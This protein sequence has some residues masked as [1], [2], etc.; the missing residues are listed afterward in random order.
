MDAG[1]KIYELARDNNAEILEKN[2]QFY[3]SWHDVRLQHW[4]NDA[5]V[6]DQQIPGSFDID[7]YKGQT[8]VTLFQAAVKN[9]QTKSLGY[10]VYIDF[11]ILQ[12]YTFVKKD[13]MPCMYL[14]GTSIETLSKE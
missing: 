11:T 9:V 1:E 3:E 5:S 12:L 10:N 2:W 7:T 6:L 8:W 13:G 14:L 4:Q